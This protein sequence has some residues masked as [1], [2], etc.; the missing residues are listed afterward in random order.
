MSNE[1]SAPFMS[2]KRQ[3]LITTAFQ[4]FYHKG[5]HAVG[6]NEVLAESGIAKKTLYHH[7]KSKDELVLAVVA[8]R[9]DAFLS[10]FSSE[11]QAVESKQAIIARIFE[12]L[13]DWFHDRIAALSSFNGC[14]FVN[15]S[16]E[17]SDPD[18]KI[19][20]ACANHK[21]AFRAM[22][23]TKLHGSD[24]A[25]SSLLDGLCLLKEGAI[26][27]AFVQ[28]DL[29]SAIKAKALAERLYG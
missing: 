11:L 10:W 24:Q 18:C 29:T 17:F 1:I 19:H 28:G 27:Q 26:S 20:Q 7:F 5:V 14:F 22:L 21:D 25:L 23:K 12:C 2:A 6:I 3:A 4:L 16:A 15:V 8:F 9:N 13:D